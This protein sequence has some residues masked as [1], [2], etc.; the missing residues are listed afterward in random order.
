MT[1]GLRNAAQPCRYID[2]IIRD[3]PGAICICGHLLIAS[4]QESHK[5]DLDLVLANLAIRHSKLLKSA[6]GQFG[7]QILGF[8]FLQLAFLKVPEKVQ[9]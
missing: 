6:F 3:I 2:S 4:D 1:F 7:T 8:R 5:S 9:F